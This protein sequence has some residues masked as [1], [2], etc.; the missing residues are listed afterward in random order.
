M[1][2]GFSRSAGAVM[3]G[4]AG[5]R[6]G[7]VVESGRFPASRGMTLLADVAAFDVVGGFSRGRGPVVA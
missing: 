5:P 6:H 1:A 3:T 7:P 4:V 2:R